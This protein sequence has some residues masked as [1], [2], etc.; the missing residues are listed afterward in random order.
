MPNYVTTGITGYVEQNRDLLLKNFGLAGTGTRG[1]GIS[2]RTGIKGTQKLP[3]LEVEPTLQDGSTCGFSAQGTATLSQRTIETVP[4]K[5]D[6][7]V[8][9]LSLLDTYAEYLVNIDATRRAS[10]PYEQYLMDGIIASLNEKIEKLIWQGDKTVHSSDS[11][12]K[13][14]D[15]WLAIAGDESDVVDVSIASGASAYAGIM[16]VY[17][18]LPEHVLRMQPVIFVAPSIYRSFMMEMVAQNLYHYNGP[19]NGAAP[20]EFYLPGTN[21]RVRN[22][23]GL[24]GSLQI[25]GTYAKNLVYGTD[26]QGN[27]ERIDLW[28]SKDDDI[29]KLKV[30]WN[31]GAQFYFPNFV[32]LGT[33]AAA[34]ATVVPQASALATIAA[35][36]TGLNADAKV[37]KTQ[38]QGQ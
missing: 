23:P 33:F 22:T 1:A 10:L 11:D 27:N 8:C 28:F 5:V 35:Q 2:I 18:A 30:L 37:F 34:P 24:E 32:V 16:Q 9:D 13:W 7:D 14:I 25:V 15:G 31:S 20:E 12:L 19:A 4:I 17:A 21:C 3:Y 6:M 36:I 38:A 29:W 26:M